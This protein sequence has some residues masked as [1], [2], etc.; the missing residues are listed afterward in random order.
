MLAPA[1]WKFI[2]AGLGVL[3]VLILVFQNWETQQTDVFFWSVSMPRT[4]LLLLTL[5]AGLGI[6]FVLGR[7]RR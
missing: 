2:A 1:R 5:L 4:V 3:L 7:R 6:G